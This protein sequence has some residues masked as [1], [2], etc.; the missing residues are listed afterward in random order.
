MTTYNKGD[1]VLVNF[2]YSEEKGTKL[3]PAIIIN[4]D[5]Y[6]CSRGEV[7]VAAIT[8]KVGRL[9]AG[10]FLIAG[11]KEAG[12]LYPSVLTGILRTIKQSMINRKLGVM[13]PNDIA[14]I[15]IAL[16]EALGL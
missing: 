1:V 4:T 16:R 10:D 15:E 6:Y 7:I 8:S 2:V 12:L 14:S 5:S 3:R 9:F 11:W 13:P